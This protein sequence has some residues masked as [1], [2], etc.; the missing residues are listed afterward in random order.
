MSINKRMFNVIRHNL[1]RVTALTFKEHGLFPSIDLIL[2]NY[3][4]RAGGQAVYRLL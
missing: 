1:D 3:S 4:A 2:W